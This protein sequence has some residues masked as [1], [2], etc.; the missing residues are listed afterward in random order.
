MSLQYC[1]C[2]RAFS[3][4]IESKLL[5]NSEHVWVKIWQKKNYMIQLKQYNTKCTRSPNAFASTQCSASGL[6]TTFR[7]KMLCM[8]MCHV[9][10]LFAV[11]INGLDECQHFQCE[12]SFE[13]WRSASTAKCQHIKAGD[14][15]DNFK[16]RWLLLLFESKQ[17]WIL[18]IW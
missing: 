5:T 10:S 7:G 15:S 6:T 11:K 14:Y 9:C 3:T 13:N 16:V 4:L 8:R 17:M 2:A 1:V 18:W 12:N